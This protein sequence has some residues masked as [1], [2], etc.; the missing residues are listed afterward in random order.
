MATPT[1]NVPGVNLTGVQT[2]ESIPREVRRDP[3][4]RAE[5]ERLRRE[6]QTITANTPFTFGGG[7]VQNQMM[8]LLQSLGAPIHAPSGPSE[9]ITPQGR[10][11]RR[12][13]VLEFI[14]D[15]ALKQQRKKR[16][17]LLA[18]F[19]DQLANGLGPERAAQ[20]KA[21]SQAFGDK[22]FK[23]SERQLRQV[24]LG[25][26]RAG[27]S[28]DDATIN[29]A[30]ETAQQAEL[31]AEDLHERDRVATVQ[32]I[33]TLQS[34]VNSDVAA[35]QQAQGLASN[36]R[37]MD[38]QAATQIAGINAQRQSSALQGLLGLHQLDVNSA[39]QRQQN[40]LASRQGGGK[41]GDILTG[42]AMG[43]IQGFI[44]G[45]PVGAAAG[46]GIGAAGPALQGRSVQPAQRG[47]L[48]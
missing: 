24:E 9:I 5:I 44:T 29:L 47:I 40:A 34:G 33:Q 17:A 20:I 28:L 26:G 8:G 13:N 18:Q 37:G 27:S 42:A 31:L 12:G 32:A 41:G 19:E 14:E 4:F 45:G 15:P 38:L 39:L 48:V 43:G 35:A 1:V 16:E 22:L 11:V 7:A 6:G 46:A 10:L 21:K 3:A 36:L 2:I 23:T 30:T 25:R